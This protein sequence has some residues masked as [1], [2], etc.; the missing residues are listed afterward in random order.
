MSDVNNQ[1][2]NQENVSDQVPAGENPAISEIELL[3]SRARMMGIDFSNNIGLETLKSK[4]AAKLD[5]TKDEEIQPD[6]LDETT[7]A[8]APNALEIGAGVDPESTK[9][10]SLSDQMYRENMY[11][12][13]C[14]VT[15]LNPNKKDLPGE[16]VTVANEVLGTI[17]KFIPFGEQSDEGYH[18]PKCLYDLLNAR[19]FQSIRVTKDPRTGMERVNTSW[20]REFALEVLPQLTPAEL[21]NLAQAQI[22]AGS[23]DSGDNMNSM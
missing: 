4:I 16:V 13:R 5:G 6:T 11:L 18:I 15:N 14:R 9:P 17:S 2:N 3:K 1:E 21:Q 12:I 10:E 23:I 7:E 19:R 8:Y 20:A 22:A